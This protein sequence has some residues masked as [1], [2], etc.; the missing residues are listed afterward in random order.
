MGCCADDSG[1]NPDLVRDPP[2]WGPTLPLAGPP[3][4]PPSTPLL[5]PARTGVGEDDANGGGGG[6]MP[7]LL[8]PSPTPAC[9]QG[10]D[11]LNV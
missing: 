1:D 8:P 7:A 11:Q 6:V 2:V 10:I 3:V 9:Q 4:L 5:L